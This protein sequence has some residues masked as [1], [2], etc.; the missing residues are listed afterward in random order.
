MPKLEVYVISKRNLKRLTAFAK[1]VMSTDTRWN[2]KVLP[3]KSFLLEGFSKDL[4]HN[5]AIATWGILRG[6]GTLLQ[7][8]KKRNIDYYFMDHGYFKGDNVNDEWYRIVKNNHSCT[9][10]KFVRDER[11]KNF[12]E[13][14]NKL[15]PWKDQFNCGQ[16]ILVCPPTHAVS[17][18]KELEYDW[19]DSIVSKLKDILPKSEHKFIKIRLKPNE[20]IV[21]ERGNLIKLEP[22]NSDVSVEE[23][24][25]NCR[26]V[27]A[28]NSNVALQAT[29]MGIPVIVG[30]ISPCKPISFEIDDLKKNEV[31]LKNH[32]N[33]EPTNRRD[34]LYWLANNQWSLL[35]IE[36][37]E[38]WKMLQKH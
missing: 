21:D 30:E 29:L 23:D 36:R 13:K 27:I 28:Y 6:S 35:E 10:L 32:F 15:M 18:Y 14:T 31:D 3:L 16:N 7:E 33:T 1:G 26:C 34:L 20:P 8:A 37:G 2:V 17:W 25:N 19:C 38:A 22:N 9:S 11:W 4:K 24:L 5:D 12:F